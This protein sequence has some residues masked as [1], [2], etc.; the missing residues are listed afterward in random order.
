MEEDQG[1]SRISGEGGSRAKKQRAEGL[2]G[3]GSRVDDRG[4]E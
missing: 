4:A 2:K 1:G 3:H